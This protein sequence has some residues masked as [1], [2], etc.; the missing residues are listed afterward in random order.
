MQRAVKRCRND[1]SMIQKRLEKHS[2][3][4]QFYQYSNTIKVDATG[5]INVYKAVHSIIRNQQNLDL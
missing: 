5:K 2:E 4:C 1:D 3:E